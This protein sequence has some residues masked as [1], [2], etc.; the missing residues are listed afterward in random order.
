MSLGSSLVEGSWLKYFPFFAVVVLALVAVPISGAGQTSTAAAWCEGSTT[1]KAARRA[2]PG[3]PI[4][5]KARVVRVSFVRSSTGQPTFID[6]GAA[7]PNSNR[8]T[9]VIWSRDRINFPRAPERMFRPGQMICA[10]GVVDGYRGVSQIE[11]SLWD[12]EGRLLSF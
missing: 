12:S 4:R 11:V 10:Q 9:L 3:L 5:V 7:Y 2:N 8:L 1:W 6:L